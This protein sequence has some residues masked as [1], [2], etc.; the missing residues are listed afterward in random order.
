MDEGPGGRRDGI[1]RD[2]TG[3]CKEAFQGLTSKGPVGCGKGSEALGEVFL[4]VLN[5]SGRLEERESGRG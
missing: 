5:L 3:G 1:P 4:G 2:Y